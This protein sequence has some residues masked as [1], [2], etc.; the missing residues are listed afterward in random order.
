MALFKTFTLDGENSADYGLYISGD[1]VYDAPARAVSLLSIPGKNGSL[2]IDEGRFEDIEVTYPA[3][4][5]ASSQEDFR[6]KMDAARNWL[7]SKHFYAKLTDE[8]HPEYYRMAIFKDGLDVK[9][10]V[11]NHAGSFN[12]KFTCKPQRFLVEGSAYWEQVANIQG[13]L[14]ENSVQLQNENSV[15]IEG[16]TTELGTITNP[17]KFPARP[18]IIATGSGVIQIGA[19]TITISGISETRTVYID[20]D[21]MEIYTLS[22]TVPQNASSNVTF[23]TN[24]FPVINPGTQNITHTMPIQVVPNWWRV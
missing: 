4:I 15:D 19:Q 20:C 11:Y 9:P 21:S 13:L 6:S 7:A 12:I 23:N 10:A 5:V 1:G 18:L 17:T 22:G 8:Y 14:D 16:A 3:A 24:D 2:A